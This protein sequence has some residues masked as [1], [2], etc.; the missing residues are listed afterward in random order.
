MFVGVVT[1]VGWRV[2]GNAGFDFV[3]FLWLVGMT[4]GWTVDWGALQL[5]GL[6]SY[7]TLCPGVLF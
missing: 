6:S 5:A 4:I 1:V 3:G 7:V 2:L